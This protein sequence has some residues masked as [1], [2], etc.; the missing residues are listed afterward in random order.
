MAA[1]AARAALVAMQHKR[2]K[3]D[4]MIK[5][6]MVKTQLTEEKRTDLYNTLMK[7]ND[8]EFIAKMSKGDSSLFS[9]LSQISPT[10]HSE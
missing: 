7:N 4:D 8:T 2:K 10:R 6:L 9:S 3:K 5:S 1:A